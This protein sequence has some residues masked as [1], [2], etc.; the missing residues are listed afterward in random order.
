MKLYELIKI[1]NG[2]AK[3]YPYNEIFTGEFEYYGTEDNRLIDF[4]LLYEVFDIKIDV[5][6][7]IIVLIIDKSKD[8][9]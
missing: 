8:E 9:D 2:L 1:L 3:D 4:S 6:Q 5:Q 7:G